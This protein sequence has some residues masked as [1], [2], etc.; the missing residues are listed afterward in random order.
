MDATTPAAYVRRE[1]APRRPPPRTVRGP[2]AW[3][4]QNLFSTPFNSVLTIAV[5]LVLA[6]AIPPV[7]RF[8]FIDAVWSGM[9]REACLVGADGHEGACWAFVHE[10]IFYFIYGSYPLAERWRVNLFF[11]LFAF[12]AGW[13]LWLEAPRRSLGALYFF[14]VLP[15]V[16]FI[17][18]SGWPA[19][20]LARV[21]TAL[22]GGLLVT[23][24]VAA[25]G[26]VLSL[27]LGIVLALGRRSGMPVV[28]LFAIAFIEFV[29]GVPLITVLFMASVMLPLFVP[30]AFSP[31]KLL[32]ALVGVTVF[33]AAYMAEVVRAGL[34]AI[35]RGQFEAARALGLN[36]GRMMRLVVLPQALRITIPNI[37]NSTVAL[38]KDTT[39]VFFVGI[40]DFLKTIE[41]ARVDPKWATPVTSATGYAF[42]AAFYFVCCWS[43]SLYA[44]R[45][46][47]RL[48]AGERR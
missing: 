1:P 33:S 28:R 7:V 32:R 17:L 9:D 3:A 24:V 34:A 36:Y 11:F 13:L 27:P 20:G 14:V 25:V 31:D 23:L 29:R 12:G 38:F 19:I 37:V 4:R 6:W 42:A 48:S 2:L 26:I 39:L 40:F 43:M 22:W 47:R 8:L 45:L 16:S 5:V 15:I 41:V 46:E 44:R 21:D 18:L 10:R 35:P 30:P